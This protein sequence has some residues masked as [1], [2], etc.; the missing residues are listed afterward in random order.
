MALAEGRLVPSKVRAEAD[1]DSW[2]DNDS[3][4]GRCEDDLSGGD[5][6]RSALR[7]CLVF[8]AARGRSDD[9]DGGDTVVA[10]DADISS[11]LR[12]IGKSISRGNQSQCWSK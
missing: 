10:L 1:P 12:A 4:E 2:S 8:Q 6:E 3:I 11:T 7:R 5:N 9:C